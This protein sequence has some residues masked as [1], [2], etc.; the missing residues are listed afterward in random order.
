MN[1][2]ADV[3]KIFP[4][5][6]LHSHLR[7]LL[8]MIKECF[9]GSS[10]NAGNFSFLLKYSSESSRP[11]TTMKHTVLSSLNAFLR[12]TEQRPVENGI[13]L[14]FLRGVYEE[15]LQYFVGNWSLS[16]DQ[17]QGL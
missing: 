9:Y 16:F 12:D 8:R 4:F 13:K 11:F 1:S 2:S 7:D 5:E 15:D 14:D 17:S 10:S 3:Y 6:P